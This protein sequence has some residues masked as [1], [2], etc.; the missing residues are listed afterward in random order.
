MKTLV[1]IKTANHYFSGICV[2]ALVC[3]FDITL[4]LFCAISLV[5]SGCHCRENYFTCAFP[6]VLHLRSTN[7]IKCAITIPVNLPVLF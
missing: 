5:K 4:C 6:L 7:V 2:F 1:L 3:A